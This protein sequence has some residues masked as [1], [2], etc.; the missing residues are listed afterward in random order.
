[1]TLRLLALESL[2][3]ALDCLVLIMSQLTFWMMKEASVL[4]HRSMISISVSNYQW[5]GATC[6]FHK[7]QAKHHFIVLRA[8]GKYQAWTFEQLSLNL[9]SASSPCRHQSLADVNH[10]RR[11]D[12][13]DIT[14]PTDCARA[15]NNNGVHKAILSCLQHS[16]DVGSLEAE[17][18]FAG[19]NN[20][21]VVS[22]LFQWLGDRS[23]GAL[24][25]QNSPDECHLRIHLS[26]RNSNKILVGKRKCG[27]RFSTLVRPCIDVGMSRFNLLQLTVAVLQSVGAEKHVALAFAAQKRE[28]DRCPDT[29]PLAV[30][31]IASCL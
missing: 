26:S 2:Y 16:P 6:Y 25:L 1:M 28:S 21:S 19:Q 9:L 27:I 15:A 14:Q 3:I 10:M 13:I 30:R 24:L 29:S 23:G 5:C 20:A 22:R 31:G 8:W 12:P 11:S 4:S 7:N 17:Q 18:N